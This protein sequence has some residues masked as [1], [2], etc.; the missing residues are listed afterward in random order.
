[1]QASTKKWLKPGDW[2]HARSEIEGADLLIVFGP[3]DLLQNTTVRAELEALNRKAVIMG[4]STGGQFT[5]DRLLDDEAVVMALRFE[6]TPVRGTCLVHGADLGDRE[7]GRQIGQNLFSDDLAGVFVLADGVSINGSRLVEG[8][9]E[10]LGSRVPITGG[11]A[12]DGADFRETFV[13]GP[14]AAGSSTIAAV[15]FY[16]DRI[17]IGHGSFGGWQFFGPRRKVTRSSDNILY[18]LDGKPALD[19]YERYLGPEESAALPASGLFYPLSISDPDAP[20]HEVVRTVLAIDRDQRS[21][22]FAGDIPNGWSARLMHGMAEELNAGAGK[23]GFAARAM[24]PEGQRPEA[25]ILVSCIGRRLLL[26]QD[27]TEEIKAAMHALDPATSMIG[28]YSYGE[29]SPQGF[30]GRCDIHNQT[31]TVTSLVELP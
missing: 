11:L 15:G 25:A 7:A 1:M 3:R 16:G 24:L 23:A 17:R 20:V 5:G 28:F 19:L 31:M 4:C 8:L 29:I 22:T 9:G 26:G 21:M 12:G 6:A 30:S 13:F 2:I 10:A 27:V 18:E 14:G